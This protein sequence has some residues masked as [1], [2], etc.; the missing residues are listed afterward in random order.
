[1][2][3]RS[4]KSVMFTCHLQRM[5]LNSRA[6]LNSSQE[7]EISSRQHGTYLGG[8]I[9][10]SD[11][12][13]SE[14]AC[15]SEDYLPSEVEKQ[16][17]EQL[18]RELQ[19]IETYKDARNLERQ[20]SVTL[21][22]SPSYVQNWDPSAAFRELYQNWK[23][24]ILEHFELNRLD[25]QPYYEDKSGCV[26]IIVPDP[27]EPHQRRRALGYIKYDKKAAR[28]TLANSCAQ[29]QPETLQLG[30]TSK[31]GK[32][33]LAGCHGEG[34]K[35]A[36]L[37]MTR[38]GYKV[39]IAA[40][41]CHWRFS[42]QGQSGSRFCCVICPSKKADTGSQTDAADDMA[43]LRSRI[44]RDV[45]I[46][47][48]TMRDKSAQT[49]PLD[50]FMKWM[51][52]TMDIRGLSYPSHIIA[53]EDGDLILD[54]SFQ[55][56]VYLKGM[57]LP[58]SVSRS[59]TFKFGYNFAKGQFS[60][61]RRSLLDKCEEA[62]IVRHIWESAIRKHQAAMLPIYINLLRNFPQA[63]DVESA[64]LLEESTRKLIWQ[65]LLSEANNKKF[66]YSEKCH[67]ITM[68][69]QIL[70]KEP[71]MLPGMLWDLLRPSSAIRTAEEEQIEL[72]KNAELSGPETTFAG[73][74]LR[75]VHACIAMFKQTKHMTIR[76]V[77]SSISDVDFFFDSKC[78]TLNIH[79][80]WLHR[81]YSCRDSGDVAAQDTVIFCDH[82]IENVLSMLSATIFSTAPISYRSKLQ[83]VQ[84]V[85]HMLRSMPQRVIL[86][87]SLPGKLESSVQA[88]MLHVAALSGS[89]AKVVNWWHSLTWIVRHDTFLWSRRTQDQL[90]TGFLPDQSFLW[91][92][93]R[94]LQP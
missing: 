21:T 40:S 11:I 59:R 47:I 38:N 69:S 52:T 63:V 67:G 93:I 27:K 76:L 10:N 65:H 87:H 68:I 32:A 45:T 74:I 66:Y 14:S 22:I 7:D 78:N 92:R 86:K 1:M 26:S 79:H 82:I 91:E 44:D 84:H 70:K 80:K 49:V 33:N 31:Q 28:V 42:L 18:E 71:T 58:A 24:A 77:Q 39:K 34:L 75:A 12:H 54:R 5:F 6:S 61:D 56:K 85:K 62:D 60:R 36:A 83:A 8:P 9:P 41:N 4:L 17:S 3:L 51:E 13:A 20:M 16:A 48:G 37:V 94:I 2:T 43:R 81:Q 90:S 89:L 72:F 29:I 30:H 55:G 57:L 25:F 46:E 53:T 64:D 23:D 35:L 73:A 50:V 15:E 88:D 19:P